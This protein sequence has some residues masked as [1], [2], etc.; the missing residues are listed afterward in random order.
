VARGRLLPYVNRWQLSGSPQPFMIYGTYMWGFVFR[1][2]MSCLERLVDDQLN[3]DPSGRVAYAPIAPFV[4]FAYSSLDYIQSRFQPWFELGGTYEYELAVWIPIR[5]RGQLAP[6][7]FSPWI[8]VDNPQAVVQGRETYGFAKEWA[9]FPKKEDWPR[10]F[11][12]AAF[13]VDEQYR[14]PKRRWRDVLSV[15][16]IGG[17]GSKEKKAWTSMRMAAGDLRR[18]LLQRLEIPGAAYLPA[19]SA[20]WPPNARCAFRKEFVDSHNPKAAAYRGVVETDMRVRD[21]SYGYLLKDPFE[22]RLRERSPHPLARELGLHDR[23]RSLLSYEM[24]FS[25]ELEAGQEIWRAP[26]P[27][28]SVPWWLRAYDAATFVPRTVVDLGVAAAQTLALA[29]EGKEEP[30]PDPLPEPTGEIRRIAILGGGVGAI[31]AAWA[32]TRVPDW[33]KRYRITVYQL[34]WRLGGKGASGRDARRYQRIEE[35]GIHIWFGFYENAFRMMRECYRSL[36]CLDASRFEDPI[37]WGFEPFDLTALARPVGGG[38][39]KVA[40]VRM[41]DRPGRWPGE[42]PDASIAST[43]LAFV[44]EMIAF[45]RSYLLDEHIAPLL[46]DADPDWRL[47]GDTEAV[48]EA[49]GFV[50]PGDRTHPA[51]FLAGLADFLAARMAAGDLGSAAS[52]IAIGGLRWILEWIRRRL[53]DHVGTDTPI[54]RIWSMLDFGA[55]SALGILA[56]G[57]LLGG[58][59]IIDDLEYRTWLGRWVLDQRT[60]DSEWVRTFYSQSFAFEGGDVDKPRAAAGTM[61]RCVGRMLFTYRRSFLFKMRGSMGDV[62]FAPLYRH[63]DAIGVKFEFFHRVDGLE[64]APDGRS[65]AKIHFGL[66][67]TPKDAA[68]YKPLIRVGDLECW[69]NEPDLSKLNEGEAIEELSTKTYV[70]LES[71]WSAWV[72]PPY[73]RR[74]T[75]EHGAKVDG[76]DEVVLGIPVGSLRHICPEL[77]AA[78]PRWKSMVEEV[79]TVR[80]QAFQLWLNRG[81]EELGWPRR[82]IHHDPERE[83]KLQGP[84]LTAFIE[85]I[86]TWGD[87]SQTIQT[88]AWPPTNMPKQVAY[89]CGPMEDTVDEPAP[90]TDPTFPARMKAKVYR[91]M[92]KSLRDEL[93]HLWPAMAANGS[94]DWDALVVTDHSTGSNRARDQFWIAN[95]DPSERYTLSLP[96]STCA[97]IRSDRSGFSNLYLAGDWT[98]NGLNASCVEAAVMS[99]LRAGW[100]AAGYG[101]RDISKMILGEDHLDVDDEAETSAVEPVRGR[102]GGG[103]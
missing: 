26:A 34:G 81:I 96:G 9:K 37:L 30:K 90:Y 89:F 99:G 35:H 47:D 29:C 70:N 48:L 102:A 36:K 94:F 1:A 60:L 63:L 33:H 19:L 68:G 16:R 25:F 55:A 53:K 75:L 78:R 52:R 23:S 82:I 93:H 50:L 91:R 46:A 62:V 5:R 2:D 22:L 67:A 27:G 95:I 6:M 32:L 11:P 31:T 73:E 21:V 44:V 13:V 49:E 100:R 92:H 17:R 14:P 86:D 10:R 40:P 51:N 74:R 65:I 101:E 59:E 57:V 43:P 45:L 58:F 54:G 103:R 28:A 85:P 3:H 98:F 4:L 39:W 66:Q 61:L 84:L 72:G 76:F 77:I 38:S 12:V 15:D 8:F 56:D 64:L 83:P 71:A 87:M 79:K 88:E 7:L 20:F 24:K 42:D 80:T 18:E 69:P 41:P 97:R